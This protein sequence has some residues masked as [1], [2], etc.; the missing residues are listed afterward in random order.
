MTK[1]EDHRPVGAIFLPFLAGNRAAF[2]SRQR[3]LGIARHVGRLP[4][5][6]IACDDRRRADHLLSC[7]DRPSRTSRDQQQHRGRDHGA[8]RGHDPRETCAVDCA[9]ARAG[10]CVFHALVEVG[11]VFGPSGKMFGPDVFREIFG[12]LRNL[13]CVSASNSAN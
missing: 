4:I 5:P 2:L 9:M 8:E 6:L 10:D 3:L 11:H 12:G 13:P 7:I 1:S